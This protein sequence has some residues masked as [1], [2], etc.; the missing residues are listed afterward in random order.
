MDG[1]DLILATKGMYTVKEMLDRKIKAA[2]TMGKI[3]INPANLQD[4]I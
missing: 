4:K 3:Y 2:Q 1:E